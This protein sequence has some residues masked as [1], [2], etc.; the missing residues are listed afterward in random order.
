MTLNARQN[1]ILEQLKADKRVSVRVLAEHFDVAEMTIRRDLTL[2]ENRGL[3]TRTHGGGVDSQKVTFELFM[4][5]RLKHNGDAKRAIARA[6]ATH[7]SAG[8]TIILDTGT[9]V[10]MLTDFLDDIADLTVA[11]PSLAVASNLFWRKSA[12]LIVLGGYVKPWSPDLVGTLTEGNVK[13]LHFRKAFLGA[14]GVDPES[15]FFCN[16]LG[17]ANV[18]KEIIRASDEVIVLADST[19][20]G[21]KSLIKCADFSDVDLLITDSCDPARTSLLDGK[22]RVETA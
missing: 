21:V 20:I 17:S 15:G 1:A 18:V 22:V 6:A 12:R 8:D 10:F 3:L 13:S 19:K 5:E 4:G 11:T 7:V 9:S 16:D 2:L 14:D